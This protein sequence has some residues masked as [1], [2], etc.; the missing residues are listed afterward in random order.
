MWNTD[1]SMSVNKGSKP[2]LVQRCQ[3]THVGGD[4]MAEQNYSTRFY[5]SI[6]RRIYMIN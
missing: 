5:R 4:Q 6:E 3:P 1:N 2:K